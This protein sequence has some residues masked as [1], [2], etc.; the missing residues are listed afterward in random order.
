MITFRTTGNFSKTEK[1]LER[2]KSVFNLSRLNKY[3]EKGVKAL[4]KYTP[5]DTGKTAK[6]WSYKI[7]STADTISISF[8]N[9]NINK[10][11]PIAIILQ[12]GH[13]TRSGGWFEGVDYVNP[14]LRPIF[15]NITEEVWEEVTK[16]V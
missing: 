5:K 3:G 8:H 13:A 11:V 14:A 6:S 7:E 2:T 15:N 16:K 9:S 4:E 12:Y 10:G 1:F